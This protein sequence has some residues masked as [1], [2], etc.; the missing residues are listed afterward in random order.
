LKFRQ[1]Y[2]KIF[3]SKEISKKKPD[4]GRKTALSGHIKTK[5]E[6]KKN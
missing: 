5:N 2:K 6:K 1:I 4:S 3:I